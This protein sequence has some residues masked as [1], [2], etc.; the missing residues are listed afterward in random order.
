LE[1]A[2]VLRFNLMAK[3]KNPAAVAL[4][5]LAAS[6]RTKEQLAESGRQGGL[7]KAANRANGTAAALVPDTEAAD[8]VPS[9]K[10]RK[11]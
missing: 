9:I 7:A 10:K 1:L 5:K 2:A 8:A 4:G 6:R 11:A 3:K